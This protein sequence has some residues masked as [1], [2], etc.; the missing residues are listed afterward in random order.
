[1]KVRHF[2]NQFEYEPFAHTMQIS[3]S[4]GSATVFLYSNL[5]CKFLHNYKVNILSGNQLPI[6]K[7]YRIVRLLLMLHC[8]SHYL[9]FS[10][11]GCRIKLLIN[12]NNS[13]FT[14]LYEFYI[15]SNYQILI[16]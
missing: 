1:M 4:D 14:A 16:S 2:L 12:L 9:G 11:F 15:M 7:Q 6:C 8:F 3:V 5:I 10:A 13:Y